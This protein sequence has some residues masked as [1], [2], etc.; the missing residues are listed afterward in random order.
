MGRKLKTELS[1][2]PINVDS[3]REAPGRGAPKGKFVAMAYPLA[4]AIYQWEE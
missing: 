1:F 3:L 4:N 2:R